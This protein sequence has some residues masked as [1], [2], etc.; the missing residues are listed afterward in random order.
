MRKSW[1]VIVQIQEKD[2]LSRFMSV[3]GYAKIHLLHL[4]S[5]ISAYIYLV[6]GLH[7]QTKIILSVKLCK[8]TLGITVNSSPHNKNNTYPGDLDKKMDYTQFFRILKIQ[9]FL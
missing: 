7:L 8:A 4:L 3:Y 5:E 2:W 9:Y 6:S 1:K